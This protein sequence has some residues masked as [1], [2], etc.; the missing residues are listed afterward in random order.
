MCGACVIGLVLRRV[1]KR[2]LFINKKEE[3]YIY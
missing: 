3:I 1:F 2:N